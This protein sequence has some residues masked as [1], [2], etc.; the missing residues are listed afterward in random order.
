MFH[1]LLTEAVEPQPMNPL[2]TVAIMGVVTVIFWF[3][4]IRPQKKQEKEAQEMRSNVEVGDEIVTIGGIVGTVV[5]LQDN[6]ILIETAG[7]RS[8]IRILRGA[9][10]T[11]NTVKDN[12]AKAK[13]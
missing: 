5:S 2:I 10:Q 1:I 3:F 9:V 7:E 13:K 4:T 12:V 8:K 11:N 6:T